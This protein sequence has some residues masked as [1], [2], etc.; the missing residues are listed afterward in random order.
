ML[1]SITYYS[2]SRLVSTWKQV[3]APRPLDQTV[4]ILN[5]LIQ[6]PLDSLFF[7]CSCSCSSIFF[8]MMVSG[9]LA[10]ESLVCRLSSIVCRLPECAGRIQE[11]CCLVSAIS[12]PAFFNSRTR[13]MFRTSL[14]N[15]NCFSLFFFLLLLL[16]LLL[17]FIL[18]STDIFINYSIIFLTACLHPPPASR[19]AYLHIWILAMYVAPL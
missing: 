1:V 15:Y 4:E 18:W 2:V 16:L 6:F 11:G 12:G 13:F 17:L 7:S 9:F 8:L 10:T 19:P 5:K 3:A 14:L